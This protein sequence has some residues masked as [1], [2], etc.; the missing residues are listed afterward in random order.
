MSDKKAAANPEEYRELF[1]SEEKDMVLVAKVVSLTMFLLGTAMIVI[2]S[3][4]GNK[5]MVLVSCIYGPLFLL[6]FIITCL[7]KQKKFFLILGFILSYLMEFVYLKTGGQ[8]G[9]GIFW[10]CI[11]TFFTFFTS[12]RRLFPTE[13]QVL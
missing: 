9:F 7:T 11:I 2:N 10:M 12:K 6:S 5:A 13:F 8:E 4:E 3:I 1:F